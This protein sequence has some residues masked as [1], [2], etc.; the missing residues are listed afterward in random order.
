[1][2]NNMA[3]ATAIWTVELNCTCPKCGND[4]DLLDY[5][6]FWDCRKLEIAENGTERSRDVDVICPECDGDFTVDCEF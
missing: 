1:M 5:P 2:G 3:E 6:D 4:V